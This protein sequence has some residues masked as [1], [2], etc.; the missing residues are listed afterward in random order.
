[1][2]MLVSGSVGDYSAVKGRYNLP[3]K[4]FSVLDELD[5]ATGWPV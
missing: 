2:A 3:R 1:M 5:E 4:D